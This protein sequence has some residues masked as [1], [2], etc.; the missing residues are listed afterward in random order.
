MKGI[1]SLISII[2]SS[3]AT[4]V[5]LL[6]FAFACGWGTFLEN[7]YGTPAARA[8]IY[9]AW[10]FEVI[11]GLLALNFI[12]NI[13][14]YKLLSKEKL[15]IF[16]FHLGF[17]II[18]AGAFISR[19][20]GFEGMFDVREGHAKNYMLTNETFINAYSQ[21][22]TQSIQIKP[23]ALTIPDASFDL[24]GVNG[25]LHIQT[26]DF[27]AHAEE[28]L[29]DGND[30]IIQLVIAENDQRK[31]YH[32]HQG[33]FIKIHSTS[34]GFDSPE[35]VNIQI[36]AQNDELLMVAD[37][38][39]EFL[40]MATQAASSIPE[41]S[42]TSLKMATLYQYNETSFVV[43]GAFPNSQLVYA[44]STDKQKQKMLPGKLS[45]TTTYQG[46]SKNLVLDYFSGST[47]SQKVSFGDEDFILTVGPNKRKLGFSIYL[48]DFELIRYPGSSSPSSYSSYIEVR[49]GDDSFPYH[50]FM[51]N[52]LDYK[53]YRFFQAS[54][55]NDELGTVLSV[56]HDWWGTWTTYLGYFLMSLGMI[57]TLFAPTS[58]FKLLNTRLTQIHKK[59]AVLSISIL[60]AA[61]SSFAN[62][63]DVEK[64][65]G[66]YPKEVLND[67]GALLVQDMD[68]RIKPVNTLA[69]ELTRKLT[70][71][72]SFHLNYDS[73]K[74][75]LNANQ[76]FV[77]IH[78]RPTFWAQAPIIKI[79]E[80]KG[81][82]IL[83]QLGK[84]STQHISLRDFFG[85]DASYLLQSL[86][87]EAHNTLPAN[88]TKQMEE[89]IK[90]DER[91][92]ILY[93]VLV[94]S[95]IKVFPKPNDPDNKWYS[96]KDLLI[97]FDSQDSLFV[98]GILHQFY[99]SCDSS[100][101]SNNWDEPKEF[102]SYISV[103]QQHFGA[104][105][106]QSE[107]RVKAEL[108]Y[109]K[110]NLYTH[111]FYSYWM[112]GLVLLV[113]AIT[114]LFIQNRVTFL[115]STFM[116]G[117][118]G[119]LFILHTANMILRWYAG[120]YPPWS[121]GYEMI[122]LAAWATVLFGLLF[123]KRT[124]FVLPLA[125]LFAGTLL[126]VAFLDWLNPEIT[127]L[128]PVL[129]SYWLKIHVAVIVGSYAPLALSALLGLTALW[130]N[131]FNK[132]NNQRITFSL[133]ELTIL[134]EISMTIGL[135]MLAIGTFLG[136]VWANESWGR[137]WG[138]D[139]KETW[140]LVSIL[141]YAVVIHIRLVP[142]IRNQSYWFN[143]S[144]VVAFFSIIMTSFGVNYYL[145]GLHSYAQGDPLPIPMWV[146]VL[147]AFVF[148]SVVLGYVRLNKKV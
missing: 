6:L 83:T 58:R 27:V 1:N 35:P 82:H 44:T 43:K 8:F 17:I 123:T 65:G 20:T 68:G 23:T 131:I 89:V 118:V 13:Q 84:E 25:D 144:S 148:V 66:I 107:N 30:Y 76:F 19:Y 38:H 110:M 135:F 132:G 98:K 54:Y 74:I 87:T 60:L 97:G 88:R 31:D 36:S 14:K 95:Y 81:A 99:L 125:S 137:Y 106:I 75:S 15:A 130:I 105:V 3:K 134:N 59:K 112:A 94:D 113:L 48:K 67:F 133:K 46:I 139:P 146:Y 140:A 45:L 22:D 49:D 119:L 28:K 86:V 51:N 143:A 85:D 69:S 37:H 29:V 70:G 91:F 71:K 16:L 73:E 120:D 56:N 141:V 10:W 111:L 52:V 103:F 72:T 11:M 136:G 41:D 114:S 79:D 138:W 18:I 117:F 34:I 40:E 92:N 122:I 50:I 5:L 121:N 147:V 21:N 57:W 12:A 33:S 108:L 77:A 96:D 124:Q 78:A 7:D 145:S 39:L 63:S 62:Q 53:G 101:V 4:L 127:N 102:I 64:L 109:N 26:T 100:L 2:A 42:S 129:K 9:E 116:T 90:V 80:E 55:D 32:L 126:F 47:S 24:N 61:F 142:A 104:D 128:V 115:T 93:Q